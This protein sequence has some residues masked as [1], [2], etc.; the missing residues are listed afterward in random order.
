MNRYKNQPVKAQT[1]ETS[2]ELEPAATKNIHE[3]AD[4][5]KL[6]AESVERGFCVL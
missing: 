3:K 2:F 5:L 4:W 1:K 6:A